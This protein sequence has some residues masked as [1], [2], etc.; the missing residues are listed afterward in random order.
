MEAFPTNL[1]DYSDCTT[2]LQQVRHLTSL[3]VIPPPEPDVLEDTVHIPT[4]D[5][6][7]LR[8][9]VYRP[10]SVGKETYPLVVLYH[11]G[12]YFFGFPEMLFRTAR[13]LVRELGVVVVAP[14]YRLAPEHKFPAAVHDAWDVLVWLSSHADSLH[15]D[16]TKGFMIGGNSNG[17][18]LAIVLAHLAR[19]RKLEPKLTGLYSSCSFPRLAKGQPL[20]E[21][22]S[23][24]MHSL[25]QTD[26]V[27]DKLGNIHMDAL[28]ETLY[29]ADE[30]S[31]LYAPLV[32]PGDT[33]HK[34]LPRVYSQVCGREAARD[35]ALAFDDLLKVD[36]VPTRLDVYGGL[37]HCFWY[38]FKQHSRTSQW[39][40]DTVRGFQWLLVRD[41]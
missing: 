13:L 36:G 29:E 19:D 25:T 3:A 34:G 9:L 11:A 41:Q 1:I 8:S 22:Y 2:A 39:E 31:E 23:S 37:P 38:P 33:S 27:S 20:A 10:Q 4:R 18:T 24:R 12:A 21:K 16:V 15:A 14:S 40:E 26:I 35:L 30:T 5:S 32:W 17:G 7:H 6:H 28:G